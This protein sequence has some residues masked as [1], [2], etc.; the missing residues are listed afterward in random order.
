MIA[1]DGIPAGIGAQAAAT[2]LFDPLNLAVVGGL[3]CPGRHALARS[4]REGGELP[5]R[6]VD[7][8]LANHICEQRPRGRVRRLDGRMSGNGHRESGLIITEWAT[9]DWPC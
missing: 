9:L 6:L 2:V 1:L 4:E 3:I 8:K 5:Q 7:G